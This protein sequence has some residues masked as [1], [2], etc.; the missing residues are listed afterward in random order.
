ME[1]CSK[2]GGSLMIV[3]VSRCRGR[4]ARGGAVAVEFTLVFSCFLVFFMTVL[5]IIE[6]ARALMVKDQLQNAA[7][8]GAR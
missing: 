1:N 8:Q 3:R 7:I 4:T 2:G 5:A 6:I